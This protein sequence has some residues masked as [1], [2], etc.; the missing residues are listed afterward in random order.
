MDLGFERHTLN[1]YSIPYCVVKPELTQ[2]G[3]VKLYLDDIQMDVY[4]NYIRHM[5]VYHKSSVTACCGRCIYLL[6]AAAF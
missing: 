1:W 5:Y 2:V 6:T 4:D 3:V